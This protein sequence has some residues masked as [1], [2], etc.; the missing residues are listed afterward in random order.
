MLSRAIIR[1]TPLAARAFSAAPATTTGPR[2]VPDSVFNFDPV[3]KSKWPSRQDTML[4]EEWHEVEHA[5]KST[6]FWSRFNMFVAIPALI[7][8]MAICVPREIEHMHHLEEHP[9]EYTGLPHLRKRKN[10][11]PWGNGDLSLFHNP[12]CNPVPPA[13]E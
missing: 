11:F 5:K 12:I 3:D 13:E 9:N 10:P 8:I 4:P 7:A 1:R 6:T 2:K